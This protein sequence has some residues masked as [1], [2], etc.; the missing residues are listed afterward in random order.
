MNKTDL[1]VKLM[2]LELPQDVVNHSTNINIDA[3]MLSLLNS[4]T[5]A[6]TYENQTSR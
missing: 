5:P 4:S 6:S 1:S 3:H 2:P